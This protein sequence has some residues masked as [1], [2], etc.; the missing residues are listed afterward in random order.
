MVIHSSIT[1]IM[2]RAYSTVFHLITLYMRCNK[3][4]GRVSKIWTAMASVYF[5]KEAQLQQLAAHV[6]YDKKEITTKTKCNSL[7]KSFWAIQQHYASH[8]PIYKRVSW[9][10]A[11]QNF[12]WHQN[13]LAIQ[14]CKRWVACLQLILYTNGILFNKIHSQAHSIHVRSN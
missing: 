3:R 4:S 11:T 1:R 7:Y 12:E 14:F 13:E 8:I 5:W 2:L 6:G 9:K 10:H